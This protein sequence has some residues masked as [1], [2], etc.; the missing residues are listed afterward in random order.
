MKLL[1]T[2]VH[3]I[4]NIEFEYK[5]TQTVLDL[6]VI[7]KVMLLILQPMQAPLIQSIY[8]K[9]GHSSGTVVQSCCHILLAGAEQGWIHLTGLL[10]GVLNIIPSTR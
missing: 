10:N 9:L 1:Q 8:D 6:K 4:H 2:S 7:G 5:K 3:V